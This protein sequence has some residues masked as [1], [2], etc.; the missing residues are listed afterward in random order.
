MI[1]GRN[2][3]TLIATFVKQN[4]S[5]SLFYRKLFRNWIV[6]NNIYVMIFYP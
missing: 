2:V 5:E 6:T 4:V 1:L 3:N